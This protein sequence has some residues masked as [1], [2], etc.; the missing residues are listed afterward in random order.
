MIFSEKY[1]ENLKP[2]Y[3][4]WASQ[5][6]SQIGSSMSSFAM[7]LY[8]L[9]RSGSAMLSGLLSI[10]FYIP[11]SLASFF[12]GV[13]AD[14]YPKKRTIQ[15]CDLAAAAGSLLILVLLL[16]AKLEIWQMLVMNIINGI[17]NAFQNPASETAM[18]RLIPPRHIQKTSGLRALSWSL[19]TFFHPLLASALYPLIHLQGILVVDLATFICAFTVLQ[20]FICIPEPAKAAKADL[21]SSWFKELK[22]GLYWLKK[23]KVISGLIVFM[24]AVNFNASAF[25]NALPVYLLGLS[26]NTWLVGLVS[27]AAGAAMILSSLAASFL[28]APENRIRVIVLSM[29]ISLTSDNFLMPFVHSA[30]ALVFAQF[31]GYL[32]VPLLNANL[33]AIFQT[34]VPDSMQGR[35]YSCRNAIQFL[36]IPLG[37]LFSGWMIDYATPWLFKITNLNRLFAH[38]QAGRAGA[39]I[40]ILGLTGFTSCLLAAFWF[41]RQKKAAQ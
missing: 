23:H 13:F 2:F 28:P 6:A 12:S 11:F 26:G 5:L 36:T 15:I 18:N 25:D 32:P 35:V 4:M 22:E 41:F 1:N 3:L 37:T 33:T 14:R 19:N 30:A 38:G 31:L 39:V 24:A 8:I 20:F 17:S 40:F 21:K 27:S 7:T 34:E 29:M 10:S 9:E 16:G